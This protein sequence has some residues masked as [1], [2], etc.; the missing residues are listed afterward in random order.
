MNSSVISRL[1]TLLTF[2][3]FSGVA[4]CFGEERGH[5]DLFGRDGAAPPSIQALTATGGA[6]YAGS[7]GF[8]VFF[9]DDDGETWESINTGLGNR[10]ILCLS[11]DEN[12]TVYA[13]TV[14]NGV[15]RTREDGKTWESMAT[16]LKRVEV[17]SLLTS[18]GALYAGT[19]R[20]VY[21]WDEPAQAWS[22]TAPGLDQTLITSLAMTNTLHLF[23]GTAGKGL[24][25]MDTTTRGAA[26]W[27]KVG[28]PLVDPK[29]H[30]IHTYI[31]VMT[32]SPQQHLYVGT[33]DGGMYRSRDLGK[34]WQPI[35]RSLPNDSIRGIVATAS[36]LYV[37]T[38][39]GIF[40]NNLRTTD[41]APVNNGL[42]QLST[43]TLMVSP[44]GIFYV[45]TS[46]G[47]FRS[48]DTGN[49]WVNIS[50]ELGMHDTMPRPYF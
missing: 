11:A 38:G 5:P 22:V 35:G 37:A 47:A 20:G 36:A 42:S 34:T 9:S 17:K 8:G 24:Y 4:L 21:Q 50:K 41:W 46:A 45:G 29:E 1:V 39:R 32:V 13:G 26:Q 14:R 23:A 31:R 43:Q 2:T 15:F 6:L 33:Q 16:G 19:G 7:F 48:Q 27:K 49:H 40:R 18:H 25:R 28:D 3:V 12:G 10:F 44:E 30:L